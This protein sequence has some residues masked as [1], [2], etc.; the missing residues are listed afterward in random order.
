M[1]SLFLSCF[2]VFSIFWLLSLCE[3]IYWL[4]HK[5]L[6]AKYLEGYKVF[7]LIHGCLHDASVILYIHQQD[8]T[9]Y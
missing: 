3:N 5:D 2:S 6:A 4:T 9:T 1:P 8:L 7:V